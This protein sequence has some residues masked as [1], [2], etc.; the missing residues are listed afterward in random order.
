MVNP[1]R[2]LSCCLLCRNLLLYRQ[3]DQL[4]DLRVSIVRSGAHGSWLRTDGRRVFCFL[5]KTA[6]VELGR[7]NSR[8][9]G[10]G[11]NAGWWPSFGRVC[12][13]FRPPSSCGVYTA[14]VTLAATERT[15]AT[16]EKVIFFICGC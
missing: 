6:T 5:S 16:E 11:V 9:G 2:T 14:V 4:L 10:E 1:S 3:W 8:G 7:S 13:L 12:P 15:L